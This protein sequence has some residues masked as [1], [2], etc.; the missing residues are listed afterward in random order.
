MS[1]LVLFF[2]RFTD[3]RKSEKAFLPVVVVCFATLVGKQ[4]NGK[5]YDFSNAVQTYA[6]G[7]NHLANMSG[8]PRT[9][10]SIRYDCVCWTINT[11]VYRY[12]KN[13]VN[14]NCDNKLPASLP[15][16]FRIQS[17]ILAHCSRIR[18]YNETP[19]ICCR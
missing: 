8:T 13:I 17:F 6:S 10:T 3:G 4:Q 19:Y 16:V 5:S 11:N 1:E 7:C 14:V 18:N 15:F 9:Y 12:F 2:V